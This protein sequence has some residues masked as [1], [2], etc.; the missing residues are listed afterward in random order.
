MIWPRG[1]TS[2]APARF[3][4]TQRANIKKKFRKPR[5]AEGSVLSIQE[6]TLHG[7][8]HSVSPVIRVE[9]SEHILHMTFHAVFRDAETGRYDLIRAAAGNN[10]QD[11]IG[12]ASWA[13]G[14][15]G[16]G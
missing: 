13:E 8:E 14:G 3:Q 16:A 4:H 5:G 11:Q 9:F 6:T 15:V 10:P 12:R 7:D 1:V 2:A